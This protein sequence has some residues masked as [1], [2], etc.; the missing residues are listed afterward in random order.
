MSGFGKS[1]GGGR[2]SA[3]RLDAPLTAV[4]ST[5][6]GSRSAEL[7]DISA[8]GARFRSNDPPDLCEELSLVVE[9]I[10]EFGEVVWSDGDVRGMRIDE[11]LSLCDE[12]KLRQKVADAAGVPLHVRAAYDQ[13]TLGR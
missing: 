3:A 4:I 2:R 6:T 1:E 10:H 7:V 12:V 8:T 13:W 5:L 11:Q 9:G